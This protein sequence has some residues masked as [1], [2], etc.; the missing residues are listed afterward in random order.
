MGE[1]LFQTS[2]R[3]FSN[4]LGGII[5]GLVCVAILGYILP[6]IGSYTMTVIIVTLAISALC[7]WYCYDRII[8]AWKNKILFYEKGMI[9]TKA[10]DEHIIVVSEIEKVNMTE[11]SGSDYVLTFVFEMKNGDMI[12]LDSDD[13]A[14]FPELMKKYG[15]IHGLDWSFW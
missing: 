1:L 13:Y 15:K 3:V 6:D 9:V 12:S 5:A 10:K 4:T 7:G 11:K 14:D 2:G 8:N